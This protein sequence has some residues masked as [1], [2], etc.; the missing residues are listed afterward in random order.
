MKIKPGMKVRFP[1]D[2]ATPS[3]VVANVSPVA[4][5]MT[6]LVKIRCEF[7]D[8]DSSISLTSSI[9]VLKMDRQSILAKM[10]ISIDK[11]LN[12]FGDIYIRF[13]GSRLLTTTTCSV[14]IIDNFILLLFCDYLF[15]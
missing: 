11:A 6:N 10:Q 12:V 7:I 2:G 3:A 8:P 13:V 1:S 14:F 9:P 4:D 15:K 5:P